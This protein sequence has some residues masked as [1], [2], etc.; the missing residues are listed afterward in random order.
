MQ[1]VQSVNFICFLTNNFI[2]QA[3]ESII[4]YL[5]KIDAEPDDEEENGYQDETSDFTLFDVRIEKF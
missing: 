5:E 4:T 2:F 1:P 3:T